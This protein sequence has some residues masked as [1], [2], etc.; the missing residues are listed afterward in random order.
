MSVAE[1][2]MLIARRIKA[3]FAG[4]PN[5]IGGIAILNFQLITLFMHMIN[6][7]T[8]LWVH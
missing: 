6:S 8:L 1:S 5:E 4:P 7:C 3:V 2:K